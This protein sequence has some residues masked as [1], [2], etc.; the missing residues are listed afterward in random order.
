MNKRVS[1]KGNAQKVRSEY[2]WPI[3][4]SVTPD[5]MNTSFGP[6]INDM[7]WQFHRG[8]DLPEPIGKVNSP[9]P[10]YAMHKGVI[11]H[12]GPADPPTWGSNHVVIKVAPAAKN[13]RPLFLIYLHLSKIGNNIEKDVEVEKGDYIGDMGKDGATYKH[14]HIEYRKA[15]NDGKLDN[16]RIIHPLKYLPYNDNSNFKGKLISKYQKSG[17]RTKARLSFQGISKNEGDLRGVEVSLFKNGIIINKPRIVEFGNART[18]DKSGKNNDQLIFK[19][20]IGVEGYQTSDMNSKKYHD[21]HYGILIRNIPDD[22]EKLSAKVFDI[23]GNVT[24]WPDIPISRPSSFEQSLDFEDGQMP[25]SE[26]KVVKSATQT[27]S[28]N[29]GPSAHVSNEYSCAYSGKRGMLC[30]VGNFSS[31]GSHAAIEY[32]LP[33]PNYFELFVEAMINPYNLELNEDTSIYPFYFLNEQNYLSVAAGISLNN[34]SVF[35][36]RLVVKDPDG[37]IRRSKSGGS[38]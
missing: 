12:E 7:Q 13:S 34:K 31:S 5:E 22:C 1:Q 38:Y 19:R 14:L 6:R 27:N 37:G 18:I 33:Y 30:Q 36:T 25:P 35:Q 32:K 4:R 21:L 15:N 8:V 23:G 9:T 29:Q 16:K 2:I 20:G 11:Y 28:D 3:S 24:V 10:V 26:W 17:S